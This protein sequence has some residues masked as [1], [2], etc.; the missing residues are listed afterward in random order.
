MFAVICLIVV[1]LGVVALVMMLHTLGGQGKGGS[2][3]NL[4]DRQEMRRHIIWK[5]FYV[6]PEDP[7][8]WV[9]KTWGVGQTV[10]F[11][12]KKNAGIFAGILV[13]TLLSALG[14]VYTVLS[15]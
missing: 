13:L 4:P 9:A 14:L 10:N 5:S 1:V 6:N 3:Q 12:T 15:R 8:G 7:R 2:N 11:R